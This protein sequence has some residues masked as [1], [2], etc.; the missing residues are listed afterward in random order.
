MLLQA[1]SHVDDKTSTFKMVT[2]LQ[3]RT[4]PRSNMLRDYT[5]ASIGAAMIKSY[6]NEGLRTW[7]P[8]KITSPQVPGLRSS[9]AGALTWAYIVAENHRR[10][11]RT[12]VKRTIG[13]F[14][15]LWRQM[16]LS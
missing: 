16:K 11:R 9:M 3:V 5:A 8:Y 12:S 7:H 15:G 14:K 6:D 13:I 4:F 2:L 10:L 1:T